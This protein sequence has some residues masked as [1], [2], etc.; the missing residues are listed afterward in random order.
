MYE[1]VG[2]FF[3]VSTLLSVILFISNNNEMM[4]CLVQIGLN[5]KLTL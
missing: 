4:S 5:Q 2:L 1:V 3:L